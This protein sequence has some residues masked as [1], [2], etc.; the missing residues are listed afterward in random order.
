MPPLLR[1]IIKLCV[2]C[3]LYSMAAYSYS[4]SV[5]N[6]SSALINISSSAITVSSVMTVSSPVNN[7][8][9]PVINVGSYHCPPFVMSVHPNGSPQSTSSGLSILLW[10]RIANSLDL[11]YQIKNYAL[12]D[13]LDEIEAGNVEVG[14]SCISITPERELVMDFSHSFYETHLAIAVKEKSYLR[15]F[16]DLITN[17]TL[18]I[19][20][21]IIIVLAGIIG[22]IFYK[23]EH[24]INEK[25]YSMPSKR[26]QWLEAFIL[27]LLFITKGPFNYFEFKTLTG[28][29]LTVLLGITSTLFI[30][31][32]TAILA[33]TF[34]LGLMNS[35]IKGPYD[36]IHLN[37]GAKVSTTSSIY[38][39]NLG[40]VHQTFNNI[41]DMLLA[42]NNGEV[43]AIV[44]DNA[45][46]KY[47][48]KQ[49]KQEGRY[50][51]I[52][53]LPYQFEK[54]NY[55]L[56]IKDSSPYTE[57]L[58]R[59]LLNVRQSPEWQQ[60]LNQYFAEY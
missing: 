27:G 15:S 37:V 45:I 42:L 46:L 50:Q 16:I 14:I 25:L 18:L 36:L 60:A 6:I 58:N 54:Q 9:N 52:S 5:I 8:S 17:K 23:L 53:A 41:D 40:I 7:I 28:R 26:A 10:Q 47:K 57:Q 19:I 30:A 34:T 55:G 49:A 38:L 33:S 31:S 43:D 59:A 24:H 12:Q 1:S 20:L 29:V 3:Y 32:I 11:P 44:E 2:F 35:D 22:G 48:L 4:S 39:T 13:L 56:A 21:A 51:H